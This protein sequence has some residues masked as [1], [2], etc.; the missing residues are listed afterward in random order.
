MFRKGEEVRRRRVEE[1]DDDLRLG[2]LLLS[3]D[4]PSA[5]SK[6]VVLTGD[7]G[8]KASSDAFLG[9]LTRLGEA[10]LA[11]RSWGERRIWPEPFTPGIERAR[12]MGGAEGRVVAECDRVWEPAR[13]EAVRGRK[14]M[15]VGEGDQGL[16]EW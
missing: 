3:E 7:I 14:G 1:L 5:G 6:T 12:D 15:A 13:G 11:G 10:G 8:G 2:E 4:R 16:E 9:V